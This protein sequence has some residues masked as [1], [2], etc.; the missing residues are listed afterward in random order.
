MELFFH[1]YLLSLL[2][3]SSFISLSVLHINKIIITINVFF[4]FSLSLFL[5]RFRMWNGANR[6]FKNS[7][8]WKT[9]SVMR[10]SIFFFSV[11]VNKCFYL[12]KK[13]VLFYY[14]IVNLHTILYYF[15]CLSRFLTHFFY[16][17]LSLFFFLDLQFITFCHLEVC[18]FLN[19]SLNEWKNFPMEYILPP[20]SLAVYLFLCLIR[21][22]VKKKLHKIW[23]LQI[24]TY[25]S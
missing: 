12:K 19:F 14:C 1:P 15:L 13:K 9:L 24:E 11:C 25:I 10:D 4:H 18:F 16:R 20:F 8:Y 5:C 23:H 22:T 7:Y 3:L 6:Q 17:C 21:I 2:L